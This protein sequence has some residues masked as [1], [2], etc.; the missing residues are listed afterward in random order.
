MNKKTLAELLFQH[1]YRF[2]KHIRKED[3]LSKKEFLEAVKI[4]RNSS[5][6]RKDI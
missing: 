5:K 4:L 6:Q 2:R 3:K 1:C